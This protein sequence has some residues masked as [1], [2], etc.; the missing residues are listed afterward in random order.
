MGA[1]Q[2][3]GPGEDPPS[4]REIRAKPLTDAEVAEVLRANVQGTVP[5]GHDEDDFRISIAGDKRVLEDGLE[6]LGKA[7]DRGTA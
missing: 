7:L 3:L 6:A 1:V 5:G 2:I 4:V